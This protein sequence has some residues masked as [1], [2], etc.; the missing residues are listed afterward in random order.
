MNGRLDALLDTL[1]PGGA[2]FPPASDV[3]LGEW[4]MKQARFESSIADLL[5]RLPEDFEGMPAQSRSL[6]L[7]DIEANEPEVFGAAVVAAYSGYYTRPAVLDVIEAA[8][9]YK[10]G[11]P[12]PGG[13]ELPPF[14]D[15]ILEIP[16]SRAPSW[17]NPD[18]EAAK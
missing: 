1:L 2:G 15:A 16:R 3:G 14:D 10:S 17:R 5:A 11:P 13:Y 18:A 9:G 6:Q 12:Q 7:Q 4:L 8:C